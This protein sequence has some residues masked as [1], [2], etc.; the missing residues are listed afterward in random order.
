MKT[1]YA[2]LCHKADFTTPYPTVAFVGMDVLPAER[3]PV[4]SFELWVVARFT[5]DPSETGPRNVT[6]RWLNAGEGV[7]R[8]DS[9]ELMPDPKPSPHPPRLRVAWQ[10]DSV[11]FQAFGSY[12]VQ[13]LIDDREMVRIPFAVVQAERGATQSV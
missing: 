9:F 4:R 3:V 12:V 7:L 6:I 5:A 13:V 11:E 1:D 10:Y 2:F 8:T